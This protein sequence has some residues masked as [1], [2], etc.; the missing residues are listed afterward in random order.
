MSKIDL[1]KTVPRLY[2]YSMYSRQLLAWPWSGR[3]EQAF[4][5]FP[6]AIWKGNIFSI[7]EF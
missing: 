1:S 4:I 6:I 7:K 2:M 5:C 3:R